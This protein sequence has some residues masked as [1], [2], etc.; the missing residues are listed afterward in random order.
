MHR[1]SLLIASFM[2]ATPAVAEPQDWL[3]GTWRLVSAT[4]TENGRAKGYF[5][6]RPLGQMMFDSN[7]QLSIFVSRSDLP[8]FRANRRASGTA[9]QNASVVQGIIALLWYLQFE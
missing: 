6:P 1:W 2:L 8:P 3:V 7:G 9:A 5:G 4:Q